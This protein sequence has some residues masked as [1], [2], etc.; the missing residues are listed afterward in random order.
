TPPTP[1]TS[2]CRTV[3]PS[4]LTCPLVSSQ[5]H[6]GCSTEQA[7]MSRPL[8]ST[9]IT[10]ASPLLR[11]GPPARAASVL[12]TFR[13]PPSGALP[14]AS[15]HRYP[16]M[17]VCRIDARLPTFRTKAADQ[18]HATS[19]PDTTWPISGHLPGSSRSRIDTPVSMP[20]PQSRHVNGGSLTFVF[21]V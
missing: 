17:R 19:M 6:P 1:A 15:P 2:V 10:G 12:D 16:M 14:L 8:R 5:E 13:F 11:A 7:Q 21:L 18:T 9:P 3:C 4:D 20:F